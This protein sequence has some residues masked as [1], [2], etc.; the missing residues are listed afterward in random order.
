MLTLGALIGA[1]CGGP[2]LAFGRWNSLI[3]ANICIII[4]SCLS[5]IPLFPF[6]LIGKFIYGLGAGAF[7]VFAPKMI[8]E[9]APNEI[10]APAGS[11]F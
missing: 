6:L 8:S 9:M 10:S 11:V 3:I 2:V 4:G 1:L 7:N 5:F